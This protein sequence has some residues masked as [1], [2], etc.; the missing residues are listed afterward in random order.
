VAQVVTT[1]E[2]RAREAQ[3]DRDLRAREV[4]Q[5]DPDRRYDR[6]HRSELYVAGFGGYTFGH[7]FNNVEGTGLASGTDLGDIGLKNSGVYG[8]KLGYF[9]PDRLNWLGFEVEGFNTTPHLKESNIAG[10]ALPGANLRVTTLAFNAIARAK[11]MCE[12]DYDEPGRAPRRSTDPDYRDDFCRL[13]PYIGAGLGVFFARVSSGGTSA[14]DNGV[15]GFNGLAGVRYY[16]TRNVALFGEY[17]YNRA[18]FDFDNVAGSGVGINGTYSV[19]HVV[20]GLS[21]HF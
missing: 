16:L 1:E 10:V 20:G 13:Q 3:R 9:L 14:S 18:T 5:A 19:S 4:G 8:A 7:G 2:D 21:L 12:R 15:P 11:L 6:H 17:K